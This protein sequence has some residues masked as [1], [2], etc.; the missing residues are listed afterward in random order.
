[1]F[2][3]S[4][5]YAGLVVTDTSKGMWTRLLRLRVVGGNDLRG[6]KTEFTG[7]TNYTL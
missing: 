3:I 2:E 4:L 7:A 1:M 5:P 6:S